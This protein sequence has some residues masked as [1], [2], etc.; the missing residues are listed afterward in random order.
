MT[1]VL[2][3]GYKQQSG[4]WHWQGNWRARCSLRLLN[5]HLHHLRKSSLSS[6]Q[7]R[8][9]GTSHQNLLTPRL[10]MVSL[11]HTRPILVFRTTTRTHTGLAEVASFAIRISFPVHADDGQDCIFPMDIHDIVASSS[12]MDLS[13]AKQT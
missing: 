8:L 13:C 1:V 11:P 7:L 5:H 4:R 6:N 2:S 9:C 10:F 3:G 12:V